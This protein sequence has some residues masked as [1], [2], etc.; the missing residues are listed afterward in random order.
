MNQSSFKI[1]ANGQI[2]P[3]ISRFKKMDAS[4]HRG[5][6]PDSA[7]RSPGSNGGRAIADRRPEIRTSE[8][9]FTDF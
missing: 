3:R 6:L 7:K 1:D 4:F 5:L 2:A 8:E 9:E